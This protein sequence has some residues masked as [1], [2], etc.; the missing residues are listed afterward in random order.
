MTKVAVLLAGFNGRNWI[1]E[2]IKSIL[3]QN[4]VDVTLYISIDLSVDGTNDLVISLA[5]VNKNIVVLSYGE[6]YGSAAANF[7]R[8]ISEVDTSD[9]D[10]VALSDQD[11]VWL[12][13]KLNRAVS[14]LGESSFVAYS[15]NMTAFWPDGREQLLRKS[16]RQCKYDHFFESPSAGCTFVFEQAVL[17]GFKSKFNSISQFAKNVTTNHDWYLYAYVRQLGMNWY[18]DDCSAIM[19]RQHSSNEM[20]VNSGFKN[21]VSRLKMVAS[22][23]YRVQVENVIDSF[24][25]ELKPKLLNRF[26]L[27]CNFY[28]LRRRPRDRF[29]LLFMILLG[30]F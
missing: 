20:G 11:D 12:D 1:E 9:F 3:N 14:I 15:S 19:Y 21:Y 28:K 7:F 2:Q 18:I 30:L 23:W 25:P 4:G 5:S 17:S 13:W 8:L 27:I 22:R 26:F 29:A 6:S 16:Y 10:Y 24:A